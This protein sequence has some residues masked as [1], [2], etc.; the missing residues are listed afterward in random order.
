MGYG[1]YNEDIDERKGDTSD[2]Y[3][4]ESHLSPDYNKSARDYEKLQKKF[5]LLQRKLEFA[6]ID[7]REEQYKRQFLKLNFQ[8]IVETKCRA[9]IEEFEKE[10]KKAKEEQAKAM[11]QLQRVENWRQEAEEENKALKKELKFLRQKKIVI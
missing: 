9:V 5:Q 4:R 8:K 3:E 7:L 1:S 6:Q 10:L 11:K 2:R